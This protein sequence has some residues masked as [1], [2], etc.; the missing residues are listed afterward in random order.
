MATIVSLRHV[1]KTFGGAPGVSDPDPGPDS[2]DPTIYALDDVTLTTH[3]GEIL[4]VLGPSG[5]GKSTLLRVIAGLEPPTSGQVYYDNVPLEDIPMVDRGIGMVFQSYALYPHLPSIENIGFFLRLRKRETEI[6]ERVR[7]ISRLMG[8]GLGP[9]LS[10]KPPTLSGG[11]R[12]RVAIA[13]CLARDPRLFL[14]DEPFSNLDAKLRSSARMELKRLLQRFTVTSVYVTHDQQ[15]AVALCDRIAILNQGRLM[16]LGSYRQLYH[17]PVNIFVAGFFGSPA[18]NLFHGEIQAGR[19][20]GGVFSWG[21]VRRDLPDD[22]QVVL[23]VRPEHFAVDPAGEL[24]AE[25]ELVEPIYG[26]RIQIV[27]A[28]LHSQAI[29]LRLPLQPTIRP[30]EQLRLTIDSEHVHLFDTLTGQRIG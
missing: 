19:W 28:R 7:E 11:E 24:Q 15:E 5:C 8:I 4:G 25:V 1:T 3:P 20:V 23:G 9:I 17:T 27:H 14:F 21:P 18:M 16:Q 10:R 12:Q 22:M 2:A 13:R 30:R 26:E 6:P 29:I